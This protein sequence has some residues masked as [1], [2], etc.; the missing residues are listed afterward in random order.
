MADIIL[1]GATG[2]TGRLTAHALARRGANFSIAGR[3]RAKLEDV[4]R[5]TGSP[6]IHIAQA[7][8]VKALVNALK[9]AR[10]LITCVGPFVELGATAAEAAIEAGV[11]YID[12]TGEAVFVD[13]LLNEFDD[14]ARSAGIAMAPSIGFDEVPADVALTLA[15]EELQRP[16]AI[17]TYAAP[18]KGSP[19]TVRSAL[20][21]L[22]SPGWGVSE[23][24]VTELRTG[25][26]ERWAPIPRPLGV[27]RSV[28]APLA[29][30][31]LAPLH[32]NFDSFGV[33]ITT[34]TLQ[35]FALKAG[36]PALKVA[37]VM[38][39]VR[40]ALLGALE[41][42]VEGPRG[43]ARGARWTILVE[44]R[45]NDRYRNIVVTGRDVYGLS[46]E[47]LSV[48]A[49]TMADGKY[50]GVGVL[51]P[52]EAIGLETLHKE[53]IDFGVTIETFEPV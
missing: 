8:D 43:D 52:V 2:F 48:G 12:S 44:A 16:N 46:A 17:V 47:L 14:R 39:S 7:G 51:A 6:D 45:S 22:T 1:F 34:G 20:H 29:I 38:P 25:E 24:N 42:V 49:I 9:G 33:F 31:R 18:S 27:R 50:S 4:A 32:I 3:D 37:M 11:H 35:R 41:H 30:G 10:V 26:Y 19:G 5:S 36:V 21:I 23:G 53:L 28:S 15:C 13:K 40:A